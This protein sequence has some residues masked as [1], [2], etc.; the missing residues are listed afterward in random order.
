MELTKSDFLAYRQCP[1][2]FWLKVNRPAEIEWPAP[3][4][5]TQMLMR[6]GYEVEAFARELVS[7]WPDAGRCRFQTE[8]TAGPLHAR[9]DLIRDHDD[10]AIDLFEIKSSTSLK[11]SSGDH[12]ADAAFQVIA[13]ERAGIPVRAVHVIHLNKDYIRDGAINPAELL[14]VVDVTTQVAGLRDSLTAEID[15]ALSFLTEPELDENG[16]S[17]RYVG[18]PSKHCASFARFNPDIA[19][20]SLY[21]L[22]RIAKAKL[23]KFDAEDRFTLAGVDPSE[24]TKPQILVHRAALTGTPVVDHA[25]ITAFLDEIERPLYFYDYET[26]GSAVPLANGHR[27]HAQM[28][29]QF[30]LHR[31]DASGVLEHFEYLAEGVGLQSELIDALEDCIG[32]E[33]HVISWNMS[34]EKACNE[35]MAAMLPERAAF[36]ANVNARTRDLMDPFERHY[37]DARFGGSTSIKKVLPVLVPSLAYPTDDVHDG[38][39]AMEAWKALISETNEGKRADLRRQLLAYCKLDSLAMVEIY[40]VLRDVVERPS[41]G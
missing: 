14:T 21:I 31:L 4:A 8:F 32:Q 40:K 34:F 29:V 17:C 13:I 41:I 20:P 9:T 27:P 2:S 28:P 16:C 11:G 36:L 39:G 1:K 33:G 5:F 23:E 26:F 35:R 7:T 24:L 15:A 30:S 25:G 3:D 10:G 37:V 18:N 19:D 6:Q 22:P 12:V 38:T